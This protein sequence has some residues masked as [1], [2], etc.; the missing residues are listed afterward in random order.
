MIKETLPVRQAGVAVIIPAY[1]EAPTI[2]EV[3]RVARSSSLVQEVIVV[4]DAST[5]E[6]VSLAKQAGATVIDLKQNIGKGGAMRKGL[7]ETCASI[8]VFLD[9][10]LI[11]LTRDHVEQLV[12]PVLQGEYAMQVGIRD[13]GTVFTKL[14]RVFPII[15]GERALRREVVDQIPHRFYR[16]FMIEVAFN[17][18]CQTRRLQHGLVN[19][20][21]LSIRRK[22]EKVGWPKAVVQYVAMT[23]QI[24]WAILQVRFARFIGEF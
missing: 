17:Y 18:F 11:G 10:D 24:V 22:Y 8:I 6:T 21:G 14:T 23:G 1:N 2:G 19:L 3:V 16:G 9:A 20:K 7:E 5:D 4:S 15:S 13:R 12:R